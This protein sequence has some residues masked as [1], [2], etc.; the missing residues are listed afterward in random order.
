[1][2]RPQKTGQVH[3]FRTYLKI[4]RAFL[5]VIP[6]Q[7]G[8][9]EKDSFRGFEIGSSK[10]P[11]PFPLNFTPPPSRAKFADCGSDTTMCA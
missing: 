10:D 5:L 6:A 2:I 7:G 11:D 8:N 1:M 4:A 9:D 3:L